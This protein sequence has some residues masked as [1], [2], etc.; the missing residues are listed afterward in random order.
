MRTITV[1]DMLP[2]V[3]SM[4]RLMTRIDPDGEHIGTTDVN[5][6]LRYVR[7]GPFDVAFLDVEMPVMNGIQAARR[8]QQIEPLLN[9]IFITGYSEYM[10]DAFSLYASAYLVKPVTEK[11]VREALQHLRY[12]ARDTLKKPLRARCFG[13]FELFMNDVPVRFTRSKSKELL[14]YLIDR[15]GAVCST[16]MIIGNLWPEEEVTESLKSLA[17]TVIS[18]AVRSLSHCGVEDLIIRGKGGVS[19]D[20]RK[21]DCDYY[22]YLDGDPYAQHEF[23]GEYMEQYEFAEETRARLDRSWYEE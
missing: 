8:L 5:E 18:D 11:A 23:H 2:V 1:D 7:E 14:A 20:T 19:I 12:Q 16:D 15:R 22:R 21:L 4:I 6:A 13:A 10:P 3:N 9:I 17:R